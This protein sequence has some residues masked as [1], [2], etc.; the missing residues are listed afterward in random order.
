M[1]KSTPAGASKKRKP[2]DSSS[3]MQM[4]SG[5]S[6]K[7]HKNNNSTQVGAPKIDLQQLKS[8]FNTRLSMAKKEY[9][10][11]L[12]SEVGV[13]EGLWTP[14]V[15]SVI[16]DEDNEDNKALFHHIMGI[17]LPCSEHYTFDNARVAVKFEVVMAFL[18][19][20]SFRPQE[21]QI[22]V[23]TFMKC[24]VIDLVKVAWEIVRHHNTGASISGREFKDHR[25]T[26]K[27][28]Y[29]LFGL[30]S[31]EQQ[32][33]RYLAKKKYK[34]P[35]TNFGQL[36]KKLMERVDVTPSG[37]PL[38]SVCQRNS[39]LDGDAS[40]VANEPVAPV[41]ETSDPTADEDNVEGNC[42]ED[43]GLKE[44]YD[45][46]DSVD[47]GEDGDK[48]EDEE[49]DDISCTPSVDT[50]AS[51]IRTASP[52]EPL[53]KDSNATH[54]N[55]DEIEKELKNWLPA[56]MKMDESKGIILTFPLLLKSLC[57]AKLDG[58]GHVMMS[59]LDNMRFQSSLL[60]NFLLTKE[61]ER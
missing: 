16:N 9:V 47:R 45:Q 18:Q 31:V 38:K 53:A 28:I 50:D 40:S 11:L 27:A 6:E 20:W 26:E 57:S 14:I 51:C 32:L 30:E 48:D 56:D 13:D 44:S 25:I 23:R 29:E 22:D 4:C 1:A 17:D 37:P 55:Y 52:T 39:H 34:P 46:L 3:S 35:F 43:E 33:G 61:L 58:E 59:N 21:L 8:D 24:H 54:L 41:A 5:G 2:T 19:Q 36:Y 15:S 60:V 49:T 12:L 42:V 7:K 10:K